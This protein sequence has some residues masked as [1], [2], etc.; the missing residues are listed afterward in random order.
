MNENK[1]TNTT[2]IVIAVVIAI[3]V[4]MTC[5]GIVC[6]GVFVA[7]SS[8]F[9]KEYY[10]ECETTPSSE[11]CEA[12]CKAHGHYGHAFGEA[13]NSPGQSCGCF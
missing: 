9:D 7:A 13:L 5:G 8:K 10:P 4:F 2:K 6:G 12:C 3:V 1:S 11:E